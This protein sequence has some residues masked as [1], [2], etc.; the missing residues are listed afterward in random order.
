[1]SGKEYNEPKPNIKHKKGRPFSGPANIGRDE[2]IQ[3]LRAKDAVD[4]DVERA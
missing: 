4:L 1:M 2:R 3:R